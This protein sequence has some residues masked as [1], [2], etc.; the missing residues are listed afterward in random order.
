MKIEEKDIKELEESLNHY[1]E[2]KIKFIRTMN[3]YTEKEREMFWEKFYERKLNILLNILYYNYIQN[4]LTT[5]TNPF[6]KISKEEVKKYREIICIELSKMNIDKIA[7]E[8]MLLKQYEELK[9][10]IKIQ[11]KILFM[12]RNFGIYLWIFIV[13]TKINYYAFYVFQSTF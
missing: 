5:Y 13:Y 3:Q 10:K 4:N 2:I 11:K 1:T 12:I 8:N 9:N 7:S 6:L